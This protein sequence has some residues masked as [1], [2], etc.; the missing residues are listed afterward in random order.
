MGSAPLAP[1]L[2]QALLLVLIMVAAL[3]HLNAICPF[4]LLA[5]VHHGRQHLLSSNTGRRKPR[6]DQRTGSLSQAAGDCLY[7][8]ISARQTL[9]LAI[10]IYLASSISCPLP[11]M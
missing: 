7:L 11:D 10:F 4:L 2:V 9:A 6:C 3:R 1:T 5:F 8:T